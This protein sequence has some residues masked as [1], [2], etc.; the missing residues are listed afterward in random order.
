MCSSDLEE[1]GWAA[2]L[3]VARG[4]DWV[5]VNL[6]CPIDFFTRKGLGAALGREPRRVAKIVTAMKAAVQVPVPL[7]RVNVA[8]RSA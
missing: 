7:V 8:G 5:D 4:A 1:M 3:V 6:G 2:A